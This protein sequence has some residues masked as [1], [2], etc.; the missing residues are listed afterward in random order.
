MF[1]I[2]DWKHLQ[3][4]IEQRV[5]KRGP[6]RDASHHG[7]SDEHAQ[8][9]RKVFGD[10]RIDIELQLFMRMMP[11]IIASSLPQTLRFLLEQ[12]RGICLKETEETDCRNHEHPDGE[13]VPD[14]MPAEMRIDYQGG[15]YQ[16]C[17]CRTSN[18]CCCQKASG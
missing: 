10:D 13:D 9:T 17:N 8:R 2:N 15:A 14:P 4:E 3:A 7:L 16:W 5:H 6:Y 11:L 1:E 12:I 18:N